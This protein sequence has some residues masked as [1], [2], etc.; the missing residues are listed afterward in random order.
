LRPTSNKLRQGFTLIEL[1]VVIAIIAVLIGLLL[2]A[3]QKVREAAARTQCIN[4]LKQLGIGVNALHDSYS[5]LPNAQGGFWVASQTTA[6]RYTNLCQPLLAYI[7]QQNQVGAAYVDTTSSKNG[8]KPIK[9]FV[10]PSRRSNTQSWMDYATSQDPADFGDGTVP[11]VDNTGP[12]GA[13]IVVGW[14]SIL[15][16]AGKQLTLAAITNADGTANTVIMG[17]KF[18]Q[19]VNYNRLGTF[20][21]TNTPSSGNLSPCPAP[22]VGDNSGTTGGAGQGYALDS[23]WRIANDDNAPASWVGPPP[24]PFGTGVTRGFSAMGDQYR[25]GNGYAADYNY[26]PGVPVPAYQGRTNVPPVLT[27]TGTTDPAEPYFGGPH[28]GASP[29]LFMDGTVRTIGYNVGQQTQTIQNN[30]G[31]SGSGTVTI[32]VMTML[33]AWNDGATVQNMP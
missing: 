24:G 5:K 19:P 7:E 31:G 28:A 20:T 33:W 26:A 1:L 8:P 13:N 6:Q 30:V 17:H 22:A 3:V 29:F 27:P 11:Y 23:D 25:K 16:N 9:T 10:C 14:R 21:T 32:P 15:D 2:P 18:V 4:N 12:P